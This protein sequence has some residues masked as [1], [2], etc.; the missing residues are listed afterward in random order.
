MGLL[1]TFVLLLFVVVVVVVFYFTVDLFEWGFFVPL[2]LPKQHP[3]LRFAFLGRWRRRRRP[4][5]RVA[6]SIHGSR[7][8]FDIIRLESLV[9]PAP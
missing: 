1:S 8:E 4:L 7:A 5:S 9:A 2:T 3:L 6:D